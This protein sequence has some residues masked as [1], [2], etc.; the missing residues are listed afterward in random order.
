MKNTKIW[1]LTDNENSMKIAEKLN[2]LGLETEVLRKKTFKTANPNMDEINFFV[3][4]LE[5]EDYL[6]TINMINSEDKIK[7]F[8]K[9]IVVNKKELRKA[10]SESTNLLHAEIIERP[11]RER[12]ILLILEKTVIV[13]KFRDV[14]KN[15]SHEAEER[16]ESFESLMH[17]QKRN[18]FE[19]DT[20]KEIF[21]NIIDFEKSILKEQSKLNKAIKSFAETK[22]KELF[23]VKNLLHA[24]QML[25]QLREKEIFSAKE[26]IKAHES[27]NDFSTAELREREA[28]LEAHEKNVEFSREEA[29]KLHHKIAEL[30]KENSYL[31][32]ELAKY[33]I[34]SN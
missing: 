5:N 28:I 4:D 25:D 6:K 8:Q 29:I 34:S 10:C 22:Q 9:F 27:L 15:L 21:A 16:I 32:E 33:N 12:E 23:E 1:F 14:M 13:E 7:N 26:T 30:E 3:I 20:E 17:I 11:V 24:E 18:M 2:A 31:K 19:N